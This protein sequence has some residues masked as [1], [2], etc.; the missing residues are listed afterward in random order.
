[1]SLTVMC[2]HPDCGR[3]ATLADD[4][5]GQAVFCPHCHRKFATPSPAAKALPPTTDAIQ[6]PDLPPPTP[7]LPPQVGRFQVRARLGEGAFGTV[8]RAYDPQLDREVAL[9]VPLP[10]RL[11]GPQQVERFL[12]EGRAAARLRHPHIVPL[13]EAS[14]E[15]PLFYLASA[16]VHGRTLAAALAEAPLGF[17]EAARVVG[18]L[19]EALAYAHG[20]GIVHRDVKPANVMLDDNGA[21]HLLDFGLAHRRDGEA[22]LTQ[23]G[24]LVGTPAYMAPEQI[25]ASTGEVLPAS[26]QYSLGVLLYEL[27]CGR[28]P[29]EGPTDVVL[30]NAL[31][32]EPPSPRKLNRAVPRDLETICLKAL[33]KRPQDRY[34]GCQEMA[35]DLRRWLDGE[36]IQARRLGPLERTARWCRRNP[37][38]AALLALL[39]VV[40]AAGTWVASPG[41]GGTSADDGEKREVVIK[42][43][44]A[45]EA[46]PRKETD[47][48]DARDKE[49]EAAHQKWMKQGDATLA[50]RKFAD[51][52]AAYE[53]ALEIKPGD[54]TAIKGKEAAAAAL[55]LEEKKAM[56]KLQKT[57]TNSIGMK[58][59]LI[60]AGKF[61]MGSPEAELNDV[62]ALIKEKQMPD[63]LQAESPQHEVEITKAFY[64]GVHEVTQGQ[65]KAVMGK[66][67]N[68]SWF[69]KTG[70]GKD[71]S[72]EQLDDFPVESVS[73]ED[74]QTFL[75]KLNALAAEKKYRLK[76][77]L[78]TE[79]EWE[80]AC[81]GGPSS[82]SKPFHFKSPSDS[83]G[84]GQ[85]NFDA[86]HPYGDG[87]KGEWSKRTNTVG[88][89][90]EPNAL[91]LFDMHGNVSEWC[92]DWYAA[93]YYKASPRRDPQGPS[94]GSR[95]V[96]RGGSC[97]HFGFFC[98]VA[99]RSW[100]WL[101][102][103]V[104]Y[105]GFRVAAV[106]LK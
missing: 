91:G 84:A 70:A 57:I 54:A 99:H 72:E 31:H 75:K 96:I 44:D 88:K 32:T 12:R 100:T 36:P 11:D 71:F 68:P 39:V 15:P 93:D 76:Y 24:G 62:M 73:W 40:S 22:R 2:P 8:Y 6:A 98:R 9:K 55:K 16:F 69:S 53:Q 51:A 90:G 89:N 66:D 42:D 29:F 35:D 34:A 85:A 52:L 83:L 59:V 3:A 49:R 37:A 63:W 17:H 82:S 7:G 81:R 23:E 77:R 48:K 18:E 101:G 26:D 67:N 27:L 94:V 95:H 4:S 10:G 20:Q 33:A 74:M 104:M 105:Q 79:A 65:W 64:L 46:L 58:L 21:A 106:P 80:Y 19:A 87:K 25:A 30:F 50:A 43:K 56:E 97:N 41:G 60:P 103:R 28:V 1:M 45:A 5:A 86:R 92:S 61:T 13:F 14:G 78:P 47:A 102:N 38:L